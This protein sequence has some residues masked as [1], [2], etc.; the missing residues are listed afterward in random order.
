MIKNKPIEDVTKEDLDTRFRKGHWSSAGGNLQSLMFYVRALEALRESPYADIMD[1]LTKGS[2]ALHDYGCAEGDGTAF[3]QAR[4][5]VA[6]IHG[7]DLSAVAVERAQR[8]WPTVAFQHGDICKP[9]H[10]ANVFW[11]SHT[12]EHLPDPAGVV[13]HLLDKCKWLIAIVPPIG[14]ND[15]SAAHTH[16]VPINVWLNQLPTHPLHMSYFITERVDV[17]KPGHIM[18]EE[19]FFMIFQGRRIW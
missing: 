1:K 8:R 6:R 9:E 13:K 14:S 19:S 7:F 17:D 4:F 12:L 16:A 15:Q 5:P 18:L 11:T 2:Y 3:L 10:E